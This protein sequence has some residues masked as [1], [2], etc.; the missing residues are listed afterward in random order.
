MGRRAALARRLL[1][2]V[3][4]LSLPA[5]AGSPRFISFSTTCKIH[6]DLL[7]SPTST[8]IALNSYARRGTPSGTHDNRNQKA[9][10]FLIFATAR[11]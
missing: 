3:L 5:T 4:I 10:T 2:P 7:I 1:T 6:P 8:A 9:M 11:K